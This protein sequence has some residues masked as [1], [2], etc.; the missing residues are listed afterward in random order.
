M[1]RSTEAEYMVLLSCA[2]E[3]NFFNILLKETTKVQK[4]PVAQEDNQGYI[5][6]E[7]NSQVGMRT[8][9]IDIRHYFLRD[10]VEYKDMEIK[11]IRSK[12]TEDIT[13][14]NF[15]KA[16]QVKHMKKTKEG[17][18]WQLA[19]TVRDNFKNNRVLDGFLDLDLTEYSSHALTKVVNGVNIK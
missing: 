5:F 6:L 17:E 2:Q 3:V 13:A 15:S 9:H 11:Y 16:D 14:N 19:E 18:L 1:L 7:I 12:T 8:K 4:P 10:M